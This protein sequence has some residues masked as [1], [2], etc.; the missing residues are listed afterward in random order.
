[1]VP[2]IDV[3]LPIGCEAYRFYLS[4]LFFFTE[5]QLLS[6]EALPSQT[7]SYSTLTVREVIMPT[8]STLLRRAMRDYVGDRMV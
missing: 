2:K 6:V 7:C 8:S 1:M 4:F 5:I 3:F